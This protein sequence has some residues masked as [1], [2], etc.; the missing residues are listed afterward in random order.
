MV[1][2]RAP[3]SAAGHSG[4]HARDRGPVLPGHLLLVG[5]SDGLLPVRVRP[6]LEHLWTAG[7]ALFILATSFSWTDFRPDS[8]YHTLVHHVTD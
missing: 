6:L 8:M 5:F 3:R 2:N 7:K 4:P 1:A